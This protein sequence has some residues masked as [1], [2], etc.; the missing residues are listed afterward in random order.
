MKLD[1]F[2]VAKRYGKALFELAVESNQADDV[3]QEL[4]RLAQIF[5]EIPDLGDMLSDDRLELNE[6]REIMESLLK[7]FEDLVHDS[8]EVIYQYNRMY[9]IPLIIEEFN[10][11]YNEQQGIISGTVTTAVPLT[12]EQKARLSKKLAEEL[13]YQV[14]ELTE[15]VDPEIIGGLVVEA[16]H[17]IIDGSIKTRLDYLRK[18]LR[19]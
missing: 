19:K 11:R 13:G 14:A 9:D 10:L 7:G 18:E 4:H 2:T 1:K 15:K 6:K 3:Y 16:N 5:E 12:V 17:T 8:L